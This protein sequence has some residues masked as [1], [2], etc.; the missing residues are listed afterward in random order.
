MKNRGP[1]LFTLIELLVVI[2]II[3]I[4]ASLLLPALSSARTMA[5]RIGCANNLKQIGLATY[6]YVNDNQDLF[7]QQD[8][9]TI[10]NVPQYEVTQYADISYPRK[11]ILWCTNESRPGGCRAFGQGGYPGYTNADGNTISSSYASSAGDASTGVF[12]FVT[13]PQ[14]CRLGSVRKPSRLFMWAETSGF[15]YFQRWIQTFILQHGGS[16]NTLF[17]DCHVETFSFSFPEKT[18]M[19]NDSGGT[20]P[21]PFD[22]NGAYFVR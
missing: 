5:K 18:I 2:G 6:G 4:L 1:M 10:V 21:S 19:D 17:V 14:Q 15:W 9:G 20:V 22:P 13:P 11:S 12:S 7:P 16:F 8:Y 3:A